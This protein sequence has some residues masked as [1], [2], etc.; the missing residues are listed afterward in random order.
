MIIGIGTDITS[1]VRLGQ[2]LDGYG[3][4]FVARCFSPEESARVEAQSKGDA[5]LRASGYAK[6]WAAKEACAKALGLGIRG[7]IFMK[8]IVVMNDG[9]GKP[10]IVLQG[11]A[12]DRLTK[13]TPEGMTAQIHMSLSDEPPLAVAFVA[14][15]AIAGSGR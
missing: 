2:V 5:A 10:S 8:D 1:I 3:E 12:K 4:R 11:G 13:L 7:N 6:R 9:V 15:S 14:I